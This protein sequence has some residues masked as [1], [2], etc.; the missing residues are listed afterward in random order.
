MNTETTDITDI[1]GWVLYDADCP[2][3][4]RLAN[5]GRRTLQRRRLALE[6]L[7]TPWVRQRLQMPETQ[8]L[9]EM[10]FL[11]PD[12]KCFGGAD[13]LL[14]IARHVWW[15]RPVRLFARIPAVRSGLRAAYRWVAA[16]R[17]CTGAHCAQHARRSHEL[18]IRLRFG[19]LLPLMLLLI[20]AFA[21]RPLLA[22]WMWMWAIALALYA[23]LKWISLRP[24]A[25]GK[26]IPPSGRRRVWAYLMAWPG[27][28]AAAFLNRERRSAMP[29]RHEWISAVI[30][31]TAGAIL[32]WGIARL[33]IRTD[34]L[35]AGWIGMV[36]MICMLHFGLFDL[37]SV[38]WR[39]HGVRAEP[40]MCKPLTATS[41]AEL[42][43]RRWNRAFSDLANPLVFRPLRRRTNAVVALV[44][45]FAL[46]GLVHELVISLPAGGG[47]GLPTCYFL[48]QAAGILI[49]R[50]RPGRRLHLGIGMRGRAFMLAFLVLPLPLLFPPVFIRHVILPMLASIG[51]T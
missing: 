38:A 22:P 30:K 47:Y 40:I 28:D 32:L 7:Q 26:N 6:P 41:L 34:P 39:R 37:L 49:E 18:G 31:M 36:G 50:S 20:G 17:G 42:W 51:A 11:L 3:C 33:A 9:A 21:L 24:A 46:S 29:Q 44:L 15:A 2:F 45:T 48:I 4:C 16:K 25:A 13:A 19:H 12:G 27:M 5:W 10:R 43:G 8:L 35:I 14:E 23:G 1:Q